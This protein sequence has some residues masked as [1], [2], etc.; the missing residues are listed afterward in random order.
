ME[1]GEASANFSEESNDLDFNS[2]LSDRENR[3]VYLI[4]CT[5]ANL[6]RFP[7]CLAFSY[8]VLEAFNNGE[9]SKK[10][11]QWTCCIEDHANGAKHFHMAVKL[12]VTRRWN[13]VK[14]FICVTNMSPTCNQIYYIEITL[15]KR[16]TTCHQ[17]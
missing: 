2:C 10:V 5:R 1:S 14:N 8:I 16:V 13:P 9:S 15:H 7:N 17:Y 11:V 4:T 3:R 12:D 6:D